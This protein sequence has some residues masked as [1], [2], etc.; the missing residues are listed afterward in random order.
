M[1]AALAGETLDDDFATFGIDGH[2][3]D[4]TFLE[5]I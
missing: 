2:R 4:R 5:R 3:R 1:I